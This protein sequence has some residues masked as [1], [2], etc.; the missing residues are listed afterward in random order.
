MALW[1]LSFGYRNY[2]TVQCDSVR[3]YR[4]R[5]VGKPSTRCFRLFS[6][7]C[8]G[9]DVGGEFPLGLLVEVGV[10]GGAEGGF[11]VLEG[12]GLDD[13]LG[14]DG[15]V[16]DLV[17]LAVGGVHDVI[18]ATGVADAVDIVDEDEAHVG[19]FRLG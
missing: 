16:G 15:R 7:S 8:A 19:A 18:V 9:L 17:V 1:V 3:P 12:G 10:E 2:S 4:R 13:V 6:S 5:T 11:G 14:V